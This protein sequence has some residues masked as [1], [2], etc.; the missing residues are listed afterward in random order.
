MEDQGGENKN[1][2]NKFDFYEF[3]HFIADVI[4]PMCGAQL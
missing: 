1:R 3:I 2:N 4:G